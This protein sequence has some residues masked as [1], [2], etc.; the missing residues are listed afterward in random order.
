[1]ALCHHFSLDILREISKQIPVKSRTST[2]KSRVLEGPSLRGANLHHTVL[3]KVVWLQHTS[4]K[5][6][7]VMNLSKNPNQDPRCL[8][9]PAIIL[10][11]L[12]YIRKNF[13]VSFLSLAIAI[14][15]ALLN[16]QVELSPAAIIFK[17]CKS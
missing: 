17:Q 13:C 7:Q 2:N 4:C 9:S 14:S 10:K 15:L 11:R 8:H 3:G 6:P 16:Q 5:P 1:M 12:K